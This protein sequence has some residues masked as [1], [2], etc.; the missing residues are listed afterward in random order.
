MD[1]GRLPPGKM[2]HRARRIDQKIDEWLLILGFNGEDV[3]LGDKLR[4]GFD[5]GHGDSPLTEVGEVV[6]GD[7][8]RYQR[9]S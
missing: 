5:F 9:M 4:I 2:A 7:P 6:L 3:D 1:A 8:N